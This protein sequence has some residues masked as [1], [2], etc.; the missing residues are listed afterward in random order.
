MVYT[1]LTD[2]S[3]NT[4][5]RSLTILLQK[6]RAV[7]LKANQTNAPTDRLL[8]WSALTK[9]LTAASEERCNAIKN[10]YAGLTEFFNCIGEIS[11]LFMSDDLE[12]LWK[13]TVKGESNQSFDSFVKKLE[14]IGLIEKKKNNSKFDYAVANLYID[15]FGIKRKQGQRK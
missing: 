12:I 7:E 3:G 1:R 8:R 11:S 10:E 13:K 6:A 5:P 14:N 4:Y 15:G 2:A 9:G